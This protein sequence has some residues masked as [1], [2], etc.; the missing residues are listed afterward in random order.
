MLR[1]LGDRRYNHKQYNNAIGF[2]KQINHTKDAD[3]SGKIAYCHAATGKYD[4]ALREAQAAYMID[5]SAAKEAIKTSYLLYYLKEDWENVKIWTD[6]YTSIDPSDAQAYYV[7]A[8]ALY[9]LSKVDESQNSYLEGLK[10]DQQNNTTSTGKIE[11]ES[12]ANEKTGNKSLS[13]YTENSE[14]T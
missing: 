6:K 10:I 7:H 8:I 14:L 3:I 12:L 1:K 9:H 13:K 5:Q 11:Y 2:Y 4:I